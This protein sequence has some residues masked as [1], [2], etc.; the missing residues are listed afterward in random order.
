MTPKVLPLPAPTKIGSLF[1]QSFA[2][3]IEGQPDMRSGMP[4]DQHHQATHTRRGTNT[5]RAASPCIPPPSSPQAPMHPA[6]NQGRGTGSI[7]M[8][9][10][11]ATAAMPFSGPRH[12]ARI[13]SMRLSQKHREQHRPTPDDVTAPPALPQQH[14]IATPP[15]V[16][17]AAASSS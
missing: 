5:I 15:P 11:H 2:T 9:P 4:S 1:T 14:T 13:K 7:R 16:T 3:P 12:S 6:P 8:P 10:P 17:Q